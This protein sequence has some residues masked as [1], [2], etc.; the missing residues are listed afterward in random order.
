MSAEGEES[1]RIIHF[2]FPMVIRWDDHETNETVTQFPCHP[3]KTRREK[4]EVKVDKEPKSGCC[5][6]L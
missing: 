5:C 2:Y 3:E 4:M 1:Y 6:I